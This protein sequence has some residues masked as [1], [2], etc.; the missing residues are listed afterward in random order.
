MSISASTASHRF[1]R[2]FDGVG[3]PTPEVGL[4]TVTVL[5]TWGR[6]AVERSGGEHGSDFSEVRMTGRDGYS[7]SYR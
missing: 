6:N 1:D 5:G 4:P 2:G 3:R 7:E